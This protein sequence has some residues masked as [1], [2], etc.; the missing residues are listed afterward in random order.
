MSRGVRLEAAKN[1]GH[2][3]ARLGDKSALVV[4]HVCN[5]RAVY[6][7]DEPTP[8]PDVEAALAR[9]SD[10]AVARMMKEAQP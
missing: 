2:F 1:P 7:F 4:G 9:K 3:V 6:G 8:D 5:G 10:H